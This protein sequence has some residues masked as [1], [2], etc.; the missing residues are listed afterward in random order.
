LLRNLSIMA[1]SALMLASFEYSA[2]GAS[3]GAGNPY[4]VS[5]YTCQDGTHLAVRLL[6]E[7]ASVSVNGATP[8]DLPSMGSDGTTYSNGQWTL[9]I[10]QGHL[11]WG[12]GRAVP[13]ACT[14]G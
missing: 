10:I 7:R 4:P 8:V 6:G 3:V 5:K 13:S 2:F 9:T 11:S 12:V 1:V 14:G